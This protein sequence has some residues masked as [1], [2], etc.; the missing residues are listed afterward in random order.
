[1]ERDLSWMNATYFDLVWFCFNAI[2]AFVFK[3]LI[4]FHSSC[5]AVH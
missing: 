2:D 1:M 3:H 4:L 5:D